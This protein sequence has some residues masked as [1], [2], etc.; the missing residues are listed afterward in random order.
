MEIFGAL[1][2]LLVLAIIVEGITQ[3]VKQIAP[4]KIGKVQVPLVLALLFGVAITW[5]TSFNMFEPLGLPVRS[6][7]LAE[8]LTGLAAGGGSKFVHELLSRITGSDKYTV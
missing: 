5:L 1:A 7:I 6:T 3:V 8:V 2:S 4:E